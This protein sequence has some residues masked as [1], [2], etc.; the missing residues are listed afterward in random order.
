MTP[1]ADFTAAGYRRLL[2]ELLVRGYEVV[3]YPMI[4]PVQQHLVLR[5]DV[6]MSLAAAVEM[7]ATENALGV[8]STYFVL[9]RSYLYNPWSEA[10][11]L[12][13]LLGQ[14]HRIGLHLD[15]SLY[16]EAD[17]DA[18]VEAECQTLE[19]ILGQPVSMIS[20]H[21]PVAAFLGL[22]KVLAGRPH[23]YMP[24]WFSNI[25]Y[26]SDSRGDWHHGHPLNHAAVLNGTAL[27]LLTH[28]VWW[29]DDRQPVQGRLDRLAAERYRL[30]RQELGRNCEPYDPSVA[31]L[32][33]DSDK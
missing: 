12:Q 27:Q 10:D 8:K 1:T 17:L 13:A 9:M 33:P 19:I 14:G 24:R 23:T 7:G 11:R 25:G 5:H 18:G 4:E 28:P 26:S 16:R 21:R 32:V 29:P 31:A 22:D 6:D 2:E 3:D 20:F 15:A 30:F